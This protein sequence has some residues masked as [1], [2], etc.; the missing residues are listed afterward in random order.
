MSIFTVDENR[1]PIADMAKGFLKEANQQAEVTINNIYD[2][3]DRFW[4]RN[5]DSEGERSPSRHDADGDYAGSQEPTGPEMLTAM[6]WFWQCK[7]PSDATIW[8]IWQRYCRHTIW[9]GTRTDH[10][11]PQ[12]SRVNM[13]PTDALSI[14]LQIACMTPLNMQDNEKL[15][16]A[17]KVLNEVINTPKKPD[18]GDNPN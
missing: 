16:Q 5:R 11:K 9:N 1:D 18:D 7:L 8:S 17:V 4:Y 2:A 6:G 12:P 13:T 15:R 3:V 14:V 10:S